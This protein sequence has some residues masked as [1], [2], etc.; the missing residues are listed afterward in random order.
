MTDASHR[1]RAPSPSLHGE[2]GTAAAT[3]RIPGRRLRLPLYAALV[4]ATTLWGVL[5]MLDLMRV[6]GLTALEGLIL[7]LFALTF[8]WIA[9][10]FWSAVLG[11]VLRAL[12]RDPLTLE[13]RPVPSDRLGAGTGEGSGPALTTRTALLMPVH[14]ED[15][16]RVIQGLEAVRRS[17]EA[18]GQGEAFHIFLL[19]DT[20]DP[21]I[22][23]QEEA[24]WR[25][26]RE[27][28]ARAER[29]FYRRREV[30]AGR[31]AGNIA[32]FCRRW[33]THYDFM[34]VLDADSIMAG[35]TLVELARFM[36]ANPEAGLVQTV[37]LPARQ[38]TLFG[39][40]LQFAGCLHSPLLATG[41]GFW[42]G[43]AANYWGH[44]A[45]LRVQAFTDHCGLPVLPGEPP[46]GGEILSHDFV[47]A[48]L[49]RRAGWKT[50]LRPDLGG[51]WEEVPENLLD[52]AVRDRRW[53]QGSLQHLRLVAARG[54]HPVS[55]IHFLMGAM[56][57]LS[58]ALWLLMLLAATAWVL[59][60]EAGREG[61]PAWLPA[62]LADGTLPALASALPL[63]TATAILL[64]L[65]KGMA[66][67]VALM[68]E[69]E[70]WGGGVRLTLSALL[71]ALFAVVVAP[72]MMLI[73][74]RF[75]LAILAGKN[76]GWDA[77]PRRARAIPWKE[78]WRR[79][80]WVAAAGTA[81][82]AVTLV[83]SAPFVLW[84][85]PILVGLLVVAPLVRWTSAPGA[86][87]ATRRR[88]IL[89]VPAEVVL[90][91]ELDPTAPRAAPHSHPEGLGR[92]PH[93]GEAILPPER[94]RT[95]PPQAVN[96]R[97]TRRPAAVEAE[98][99]R[100]TVPS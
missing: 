97:R 4:A 62:W 9:L 99:G 8:G 46:L 45:I 79:T 48:A 1:G 39:R 12:R 17:L 16:E 65:P 7:V 3:V 26:W 78:A 83:F 86:G 44:N 53:A 69:R 82:T 73:H 24:A 41:Q 89:L 49:L 70:A 74:T 98:A 67:G 80:G 25:A 33:G 52:Y 55:R 51:S 38:T 59:L 58:S 19:S 91:A 47:E 95:M 15:P 93:V 50:Y 6:G 34:V 27:G 90:P 32:D 88:R 64:F 71:E 94:P 28:V 22:A 84:L 54:F 43:D 14:N 37:P 81:W 2:P 35:G 77:Q 31:K 23:R 87:I 20:T 92:G 100:R 72:I 75:V 10:A 85:S 60:A 13:R 29:L 21:A 63:L 61:G 66:L 68:R 76:V 57:F 36:E 42:Q 56:G 96:G 18:T 40:L 30:N 5:R 11:F